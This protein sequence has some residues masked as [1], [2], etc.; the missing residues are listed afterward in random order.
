M[1]DGVSRMWADSAFGF[2]NTVTLTG[3]DI[4]SEALGDQLRRAASFMRSKSRPGYLWIFEELLSPQA[5]E[6]LF[7]HAAT[8]GL[9]LAFSGRGMAGDLSIPEP[10]HPELEFRRVETD[11]QLTVYG[12]INARAYGMPPEAGR[13]ALAG[14]GLWRSDIHA[15]LGY[16]DGRP[17]TCAAT[18]AGPDSIFL[19][20]VAT[21]PEEMRRGYGEAVTRKAI[22]EGAKRSGHR[23]LVLHAT[24]AGQPVYERIGCHANT[25]IHFLQLAQA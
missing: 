12:D 11:E 25:P 15:Y 20:L 10:F 23:R 1:D 19:A 13:D 4:A 14:S 8:A 17:V 21:L 24:Q 2:W 3:A 22:H 5:R 18:I 6:G 16:R 7:R 9:E